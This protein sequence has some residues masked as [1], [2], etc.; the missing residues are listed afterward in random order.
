MPWL[1]YTFAVI[2]VPT[3][4][5]A[6][7]LTHSLTHSLTLHFFPCLSL[8]WHTLSPALSCTQTHLHIAL[9]SRYTRPLPDRIALPPPLPP[10]L[11][12]SLSLPRTHTHTQPRKADICASSRRCSAKRAL[13]AQ[14]ALSWTGMKIGF[15]KWALYYNKRILILSRQYHTFPQTMSIMQH[16]SSCAPYL[17]SLEQVPTSTNLRS[18]EQVRTSNPAIKPCT[19][20]KRAPKFPQQY[21]TFPEKISILQQKSFVAPNL[22]SVEQV[23]KSDPANEPCAIVKE[24]IHF[25]NSTLH[26]CK[27]SLYCS[28]RAL[29]CPCSIEQVWKSNPANES[30]ALPP[31]MSIVTK[32]VY[33]AAKDLFL[34]SLRSVEQVWLSDSANEHFTIGKEPQYFHK[35]TLDFRRNFYVAF[36][37]RPQTQIYIYTHIHMHSYIYIYVY[38]HIYIYIYICIKISILQLRKNS[39]REWV[40]SHVWTSHVTDL[41]ESCPTYE[42]V[43]SLIWMSHVSRMNEWCHWSEC[44]MSHIW[45]S[46]VPDVNESCLTGRRR[47]ARDFGRCFPRLFW[48]WYSHGLS[49]TH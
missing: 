14:F 15:R 40:M 31:K 5:H 32:D 48:L 45:T 19:K 47:G 17:R 35:R 21:P 44:V 37:A 6:H 13:F 2:H 25:H 28:K 33:I 29:L 16:K 7:T 49:L 8:S 22:C 46:D 1:I 42:W 39:K 3:H 24:P 38:I 12:L 30:P 11:S 27:R 26:S 23:W 9:K 10:S 43:M 34:L 41:N 20:S 4:S 18:L 36:A